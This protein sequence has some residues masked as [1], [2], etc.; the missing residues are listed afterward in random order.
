M[1]YQK[2][3][4]S[5]VT[6]VYNGA[7]YLGK[8]L[9]SVLKQTYPLIEMIL[10]DDGSADCT[11]KVAKNY[12]KK[13]LERG[14]TYR[15]IQVSH[16]SA[17]A[18]IN[19]GLKYVTGEYLIWPDSD[20]VLEPDSVKMRVDFLKEHAEY[21]C[22][23]SVMYYFDSKG[24]I[25]ETGERLGNLKKRLSFF[26][27]L[28][29]N[30]FVCCGCYMLKT[31]D[32]FSIYPTRNIPEYPVGQ[33]FQMLLPYMYRYKC[34]TI[35]EKLYGVRVHKDS[36]S[37]RILTQKEEKERYRYFERLIDEIAV[38]CEIHSFYEKR[39]IFCWKLQRR[40]SLAIKNKEIFEA[41]KIKTCLF[42][43]GRSRFHKRLLTFTKKIVK[44][45]TETK[46]EK[47]M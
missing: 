8:M 47:N 34:P 1:H 4:V 26:D 29:G 30:T 21:H 40:Y 41:L 10:V 14:Y 32:F 43:C 3:L 28:E 13:F 24:C 25:D 39:R 45:K 6:P 38:I 11:L 27:I 23:R 2:N 44:L 17:S 33:N 15:I 19:H 20:D 36:H 35:P 22:I 9:G 12:R 16:K 7:E 46:Y 5:C 37:R 42:L 18:A 31:E